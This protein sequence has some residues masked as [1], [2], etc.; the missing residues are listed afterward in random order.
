MLNSS[1]DDVEMET[2]ENPLEIDKWER[3]RRRGYKGPKSM[4]DAEEGE[5]SS[6]ET[7]PTDHAKTPKL[8]TT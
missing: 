2:V 1:N 8:L 7:S 5:F 6:H 3:Q 4:T